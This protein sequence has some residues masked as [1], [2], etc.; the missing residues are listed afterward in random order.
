MPLDAHPSILELVPRQLEALRQASREETLSRGQAYE[1]QGRVRGLELDGTAARAEVLGADDALYEV[2][3]ELSAH[4]PRSTCSCPAWGS[5]DDHCKHVVALAFSLEKAV[6]GGKIRTLAPL[7]PAVPAAVAAARETSAADA[8]SATELREWLGLPETAHPFVYDLAPSSI[9]LVVGVTRADR[10]RPVGR[11]VQ[12]STYLRGDGLEPADRKI[13]GALEASPRDLEGRYRLSAAHAGGLLEALRDR[14]VTFE[15]QRVGFAPYPAHLFGELALD[16]KQRTITLRLRLSEGTLATLP[17]VQFLTE[18]PVWALHGG[19]LH[20]IETIAPLDRLQRLKAEPVFRLP[21]EAGATLDLA[22]GGLRRLGVVLEAAAEIAP[23]P[24]VFVLTLDGDAD[25]VR[26]LLAVRYGDPT[27]PLLPAPEGAAAAAAAR[28]G[29]VELPLTVAGSATHVTSEGRL[30][31]RDV[32]AEKAAVDALL[33]SGLSHGGGAFVARGDRAVDFWTRGVLTLPSDW[34][35]FGAK[36]RE[37][38][39]VRKLSPRVSLTQAKTGWFSL[40]VAFAEQDQS[41]DLARLR[42]LLATGR[43]Y[44]PLSDGTVGELPREIAEYVKTLLEESGA[45]PKGASVELAPFE[46][47]EIER[48]VGLVPDARVSPESRRFLAALRDFHGIEQVDLP[49]GLEADL[50]PYQKTGF[51]WLLFLHRHGMAGVLADDMGLG[52]TVQTLALLLSLKEEEGRRPSLVVCPTSVVPNWRREAERFAPQLKVVTYDGPD[53]D[54]KRTSF[55]NADLV[56]TSYALLRRDAEPLRKTRFRYVVLDEAQHVKNPSSLGARAARSLNTDHRLVLTGTPLENRLSDLWSLFHF[57]MPGLL[58]GETQFR[59][60][61]ARPIEVD[62][63]SAARDRLR[64]RVHPFILRRLKDE[65]ARDL[66]PRTE[67]ILPVDLSPGQQALYREMLMTA[68]ERVTSIIGQ[69]GFAKARISI[70]TELL[71]LRQ[72]CCDPRL[73][74]LPPGTRLPPSSKLEAF[75]ELVRDVLGEGHRVLIFS[76]FTEMLRH[77]AE[78]AD[79]EGLRYEYLDGETPA[80]DRQERIDRFNSPDGAPL[81][82]LSLKAG[83][84]GLNLTAADYVIHY[85]PWWNPA[86]EQQA[87]DRAHRIGQTKPVFS[88]KII[89]KGTVEEKILVMQ[90]RKKTLAAGVLGSDDALGKVLTEKDVRDLFA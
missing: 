57:L 36:P 27:A 1:E 42:P 65:V 49:K 63:S 13:L 73:L 10:P 24:P 40:E 61:Y 16:E 14:S 23:A 3:L 9:G 15:G 56:L 77:L 88:Y 58:G 47:G 17:S 90:D 70:L 78:W 74:K 66:P 79:E 33:A 2:T 18:T 35:L 44:V 87:V 53:R 22:L 54:Q 12:A 4:P 48:L 45:E 31:R 30:L 6:R 51:D 89:A 60:R 76:Q 62:G 67:T 52:K 59:N 68:R 86:A 84:T 39:K 11:Y 71:R 37:V 72:V 50:R 46:A 38:V 34:V 28:S 29:G 43:R 7:V 26:A 41:I 85:D 75:A 81:F 19:T 25:G 64:R 8:A 83:G 55:A 21:R 82:F 80:A 69:M 20:R 32:D 5:W